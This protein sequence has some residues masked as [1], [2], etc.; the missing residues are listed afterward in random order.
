MKK[1]QEAKALRKEKSEKEKVDAMLGKAT[2]KLGEMLMLNN[3]P[4]SR[5]QEKLRK[6]KEK[7]EGMEMKAER[8][9]AAELEKEIKKAE[10]GLG[11]LHME[12]K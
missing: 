12:E 7:T 3:A 5:R 4:E 11:R 2:N 1:N 6:R 10:I 9:N 8:R